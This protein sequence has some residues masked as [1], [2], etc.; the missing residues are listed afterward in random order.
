MNAVKSVQL[1]LLVWTAVCRADDDVCSISC[2]D[3]TG[4]VGE[5]VT[6]TCSVSQKRPECCIIMYKFQYPEKYKNSEICRQ[7]F[8][9]D[10]CEQRNSF[11]CRFTPTTA[12]TGKFR[13]F[14]QTMCEMKRAEFTV[15]ITESRNT[16]TDTKAL[17]KDPKNL[18]P[19]PEAGPRSNG[20]VVP[21]VVGC[22]IIL[23]L[24]ITMTII[25]KTKSNYTKPCGFQKWKFWVHR[26]EEVNSNC[27]E[28]VINSPESTV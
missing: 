21:T 18:D 10:P 14:V 5:E 15:D 16:A 25:Y 27:P 11:T 7:E 28:N 24:I 6:F 22:F 19:G 26:H 9:L 13:F 1:F 17:Y 23:I 20:T 8:P 2:E 4:T 12:M 3:V